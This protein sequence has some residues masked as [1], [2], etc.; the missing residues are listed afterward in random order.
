MEFSLSKISKTGPA[1]IMKITSKVMKEI[2]N[3]N[4]I[5]PNSILSELYLD[6]K[7][8][9]QKIAN[10]FNVQ[11]QTICRWLKRLKIPIRTRPDAVSISLTKHIKQNF[12]GNLEEKSYLIGMRCGD[13]SVQKHGRN[14]RIHVGSTHS[15]ML[16]LFEKLFTKY[17]NVRRYT[18]F[19][20][21]KKL[22]KL[23][24]YWK[25][26]CDVNNSFK[27]LEKSP[28]QIPKWI[29]KNKKTFSSFLAGYF[30]AE[31][32]ISIYHKKGYGS[33][34]S[35]IIK[36]CDKGILTG[37]YKFLKKS[38]FDIYFRLAKKADG[39]EYKKDYYSLVISNRNQVLDILNLMPLKHEEKIL[40]RKLAFELIDTNWRDAE[41]KIVDLRMTIKDDVK[42]F[43]A[44]ARTIHINKQAK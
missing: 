12:S 9:Q 34:L 8:S 7:Y 20:K 17:G 38:K 24:Y 15:T 39:I 27:F 19:N 11:H 18:K 14:L 30:D 6:K 33:R 26:Y 23:N 40:K 41:Q 42:K 31:G 32:C 36:S 44:Y 37:I 1:P 10:I 21:H 2:D 35:W 3:K 29:L 43:V 22:R 4:N 25:I 16:D 28:K 13:I 5:S